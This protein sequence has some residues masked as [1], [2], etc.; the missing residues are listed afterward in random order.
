MIVTLK[1]R[2]NLCLPKT[3]VMGW[4]TKEIFTL[5]TQQ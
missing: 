1:V 2:Q 5:C 3:E 4:I